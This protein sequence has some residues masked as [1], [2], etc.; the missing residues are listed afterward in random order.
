MRRN[1]NDDAIQEIMGGQISRR[2]FM[3]RAAVLGVGVSAVSGLLAACADDVEDDDEEET[4]DVDDTEDTDDAEDTDSDEAEGDA[5]EDDEE[6]DESGDDE[7]P[8]EAEE[9]EDDEGSEGEPREGGEVRYHYG[10]PPRTLNPLFSTSN[11]EHSFQAMMFGGLVKINNEVEAFPDLAEEIEISD[12]AIEYTFT[13]HENI[14][15]TDG[16]QLTTDDVRFTYER[17]INPATGS[18]RR[19][20]LLGIAGAE[21]F[22]EGESDS[23]EGISTPDDLTVTFTLT[24]PNSVFLLNISGTAALGILPMHVLQDVAPEDMADHEF[25]FE[26]TVS[27]GPFKFV[28]YQ[29]DQ[30]IEWERHEDYFGNRPYIDRIFALVLDPNVA[31]AQL[32]TGD[33]DIVPDLEF[34]EI[35]RV[36]GMEHVT[37]HSTQSANLA[38]INVNLNREYLADKRV[39]QA[40]AYAIDNQGILDSVIQGNGAVVHQ[41][42]VAPQWAMDIDVPAYDYDPDRARELLEEAGWDSDQVVE[43]WHREGWTEWWLTTLTFI[44]DF[45]ADVGIQL[46]VVAGDTAIMNEISLQDDD[47]DLMPF[48]GS[49]GDPDR[50]ATGLT[51]ENIPPGGTNRSRYCNERVDELFEQ[52]RAITDPD[53]RAEIYTELAQILND[54]L[55][56]LY[57]F[58]VDNVSAYANRVQ[59]VAPPAYRDNTL[60]NASEWYII[61]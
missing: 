43:L 15:F 8:D 20:D 50:F 56:S 40:M 27:A 12:D 2:Q 57:L 9:E 6:T 41:P 52:G 55:P 16:E 35:E 60:W 14:T 13:L 49:S 31:I 24:E 45:F 26:P 37:V 38:N 39:R 47:F 58:R 23:V 4:T 22:G 29:T 54:E 36:E 25:S 44:Q 46:E 1:T 17:A 42:F 28:Q 11:R 3:K 19:G 18:V 53:E 5:A 32:E 30:F 59:G 34:A 33:L 48:S 7:D 61:E 10:T 51:C 21:A